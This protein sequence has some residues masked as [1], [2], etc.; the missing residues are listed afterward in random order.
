MKNSTWL[1]GKLLLLLLA[2]LTIGC[3]ETLRTDKRTQEPPNI[4]DISVLEQSAPT[5][6]NDSQQN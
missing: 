1:T 2:M 4:E 6:A 3:G 5:R